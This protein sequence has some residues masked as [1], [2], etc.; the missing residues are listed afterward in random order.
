MEQFS[1]RFK[2]AD[3]AQQL[4]AYMLTAADI[5]VSC[6]NRVQEIATEVQNGLQQCKSR[7]GRGGEQTKT[8]LEQRTLGIAYRL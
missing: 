5:T 1:L 4:A 8:G 7:D 2:D 3:L 6:K